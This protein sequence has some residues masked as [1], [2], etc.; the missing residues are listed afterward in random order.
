MCSYFMSLNYVLILVD[1][2]D[3]LLECIR[4]HTNIYDAG[5][6]NHLNFTYLAKLTMVL[7]NR[8]TF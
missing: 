1:Y 4:T 3:L 6:Q 7:K 8:A 5:T 2:S